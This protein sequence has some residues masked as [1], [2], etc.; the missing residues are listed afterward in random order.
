MYNADKVY[1]ECLLFY[2]PDFFEYVSG[3]VDNRDNYTD[4][5]ACDNIS[6]MLGFWETRHLMGLPE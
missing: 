1:Y 3:W 6:M 2:G 4:P 5:V